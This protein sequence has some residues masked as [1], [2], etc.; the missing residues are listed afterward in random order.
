M[1]CIVVFTIY[2]CATLYIL[3]PANIETGKENIGTAAIM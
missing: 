1:Q 2:Q 3:S